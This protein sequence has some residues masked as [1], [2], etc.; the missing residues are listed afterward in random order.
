ML[1]ILIPTYN[2]NVY[3][4]A[5]ELVKQA[6]AC[7]IVFELICMDDGSGSHLNSDNQSINSLT[8]CQF[9]E[10]KQNIGRSAIRNLLARKATFDWLLFLDADVFPVTEN[11]IR[12]YIEAAITN[13]A[14]VIY[15]G[16]LYKNTPPKK[17]Q[18]L[19]WT[20]GT[21]REALSLEKRNQNTYLRFL[22]LCF[23]IKKSV[24]ETVTFNETIKNLRH[25]DTLFAYD[26]KKEN[27]AIAH[28]HNPVYH[29]GLE[30]NTVF[31]Q[32]SLQSVEG[33]KDL[34]NHKLLPANHTLIYKAFKLSERLYFSSLFAYIYEKHGTFFE[35]NLTSSKPS[36]L[37]YDFYRL[38]Y[39]CHL[40][41]TA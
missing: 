4:L 33:L 5:K 28:I 36:L 35:H 16:I 30:D 37:A 1:S 3:P 34:V 41:K 24:F 19:R 9:I 14:A 7:D 6:L 20:Y 2:Y 12:N 29:L 32:K 17:Q 18:T 22:T 13:P 27:I 21:K 23:L 10:N 40:A 15:G 31:L 8:N 39:L 26:L 11:L 38:C 25:E